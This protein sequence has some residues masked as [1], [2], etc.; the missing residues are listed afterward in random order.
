VFAAAYA[1]VLVAVGTGSAW[2][3]ATS[4]SPAAGG[5][6]DAAAAAEWAV[7]LTNADSTDFSSGLAYGSW[8]TD[9]TVVRAQKD[10][11]LAYD[12]TT[13]ERA[14]GAPAPGAQLCGATPNVAQGKAAVAYGSATLCDHLAGLDIATGK[15]T[16][17]IKIPAE[18]SR[19][20]NSLTVPRI[21]GAD[22]MAVIEFEDVLTGYRLSDGAK[23][24]S[25]PLPSGCHLKDVNAGPGRVAELVDCT[26]GGGSY[27]QLLDPKTGRIT[28]KAPV[29]KLSLMSSLLSAAP[30]ILQREDGD[31]NVFTVYDDAA[32]K[33]AE[34]TTGKVDLL[35]MNTTAFIQGMFEQHRYA[36]HGDRL[37]LATFPEN[38]PDAMRSENKALAFDLKTGKQVWQ[39]SGTNATVL[40]YV[41]AD[42]KGLLALESGDRRDLAPRLVRLDA[43]TGKAAVVATLPQKYGTEAEKAQVFERNGA[44]VIVPWTSV[45]TKYAVSYINTKDG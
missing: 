13:G 1:V 25:T 12:L 21:L 38:V 45:A 9:R 40:T 11:V 37:Y 43:A 42:D 26:F 16:W 8:L 35:A 19:L 3:V 22:G 20:A 18:K 6:N 33:V 31:K 44:V 41:R 24:W 23:R 34:F 39:S 7:P 32:A 5:G 28:R 27:I 29:G 4:G 10:G 30:V 15:L 17:K 14:W 36:V 2:F